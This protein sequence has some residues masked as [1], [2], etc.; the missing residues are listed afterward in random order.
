MRCSDYLKNKNVNTA[1]KYFDKAL[2]IHPYNI[3]IL[4]SLGRCYLINGQNEI[5]ISYFKKAIQIAPFF[6][7]ALYNLAHNYSLTAN[8]NQAIKA[9][10]KI[11]Y[12]K[13]KKFIER[14]LFYAKRVI[15]RKLN[16]PNLNE[17]Y[18]DSLIKIFSNDNWISSI[19]IKSYNNEV[20]FDEQLL[21]D[22]KYIKD[23]NSNP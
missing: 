4:N 14:S 19:V 8:Y 9:L 7:N 10:Q 13:S 1:I 23:Q 20:S 2:E 17:L 21:L 6:E 12:K 18:K 22:V 3:H 15:K 16:E 5:S 11:E